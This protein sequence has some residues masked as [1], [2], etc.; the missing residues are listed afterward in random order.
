MKQFLYKSAKFIFFNFIFIILI[1]LIL[2]QFKLNF[3]LVLNSQNQNL[4]NISKIDVGFFGD[5]HLMGGIDFYSFTEK[6]NKTSFSF[7]QGGRP[8]YF[9][10]ILIE[11]M[12]K[13][14]PQMDVVVSFGSHNASYVGTFNH[15]QDNLFSETSFKDYTTLY[16]YL[17]N[18]NDFK[19]FL[20]INFFKTLQS[21]IK[22]IF[23]FDFFVFT[24]VDYNPN[25]YKK[26]YKTDIK[27]TKKRIQKSKSTNHILNYDFEYLRMLDVIEKFPNSKFII[28]RT[29]ETKK[30]LEIYPQIYYNKFIEKLKNY[31]NVSFED[32]STVEL[33]YEEDF[34]DLTHLSKNGMKKFTDIF[35]NYYNSIN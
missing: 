31:D 23:S 7:S 24:G 9:T 25:G 30:A 18:L 6:T 2:N 33:N 12:L 22:S 16:C 15:L 26:N 8:L 10:S 32:F 13:I 14:N 20:N 29:P 21:F 11:N 28:I 17:F 35:I 3:S 5:S 19:Y 27:L 4:E 34:N 1:I